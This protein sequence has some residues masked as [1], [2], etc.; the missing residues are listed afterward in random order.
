MNP[1]KINK[2]DKYL[3]KEE[4]RRMKKKSLKKINKAFK[5]SLRRSKK[6]AFSDIKEARI[7]T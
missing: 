3:A 4:N 2:M 1:L 7:N 6:L 5:T